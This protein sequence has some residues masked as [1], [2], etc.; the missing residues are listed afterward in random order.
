MKRALLQVSSTLE[1]SVTC[2]WGQGKIAILPL[3][4]KR[5]QPRQKRSWQKLGEEVELPSSR[6]G[7]QS[8]DLV[9]KEK[10]KAEPRIKTTGRSVVWENWV[11]TAQS[12]CSLELVI[13]GRIHGLFWRNRYS[14]S[15]QAMV[16]WILRKSPLSVSISLPIKFKIKCVQTSKPYKTR[17]PVSLRL[18]ERIYPSSSCFWLD[19]LLQLNPPLTHVSPLASGAWPWQFLCF[20]F[21]KLTPR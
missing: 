8:W 10:W 20:A 6:S 5:R 2:V 16:L 13:P 19:F 7:V 4:R 14:W 15:R 12:C 18:S 11:H 9:L 3:S 17:N 1:V 21:E